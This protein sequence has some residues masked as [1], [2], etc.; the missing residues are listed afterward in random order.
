MCRLYA[1][2]ANEPTRV[3]CSLVHSQNALM[4]QSR[5]DR[6]G[7]VH[8]HG[9]GVADYSDVLPVIEKTAWAAYDGEH[10][11]KRAS[12][13]YAHTVVAH[14]RQATIGAPIP[15]NTHP[16]GHGRWAF[17]HNGTLPCFEEVRPRL[18]D[19]IDPIHRNLIHGSTDSEHIFHFLLTL[20]AANPQ[21][22][23]LEV[24]RRGLDQVVRWCREA[25]SAARPGLNI[26]LTDGEM[27]VGSRLNRTLWFLRREERF[28]CAVCGKLHV[29]QE[30]RHA[31]RSIEIASEPLTDEAGWKGVPDGTVYAVDPDFALRFK[32]LAG[33]ADLRENSCT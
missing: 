19:A 6:E 15:E 26:V 20:L 14:V 32:P 24:V 29:H 21:L 7:Q 13:V 10:F 4:A 22:D 2:R 3:E 30:P 28:A 12:R 5:G 31:Y 25:D 18:L 9:W 27:L 1:L 17:A 33:I 23:P 8:G 16:F 11:A